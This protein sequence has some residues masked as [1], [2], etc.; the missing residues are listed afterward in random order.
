M[1]FCSISCFTLLL[2]VIG[3]KSHITCIYC[4]SSFLVCNWLKIP[5]HMFSCNSSIAFWKHFF[6]F[7]GWTQRESISCFSWL[8]KNRKNRQ[9]AKRSLFFPKAMEIFLVIK[10][11]KL[12]E[13]LKEKVVEEVRAPTCPTSYVGRPLEFY[14]FHRLR[15]WYMCNKLQGSQFK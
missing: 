8:K 7:S 3:L 11:F 9:H 4:N 2:N 5:H 15:K 14:S 10:G 1:H 6:F 13:R 12:T